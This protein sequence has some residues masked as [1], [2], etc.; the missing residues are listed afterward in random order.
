MPEA[1]FCRKIKVVNTN[2]LWPEYTLTEN[3]Y[4]LVIPV[5]IG[6]MNPLR[7]MMIICLRFRI[8]H[9]RFQTFRSVCGHRQ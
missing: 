3:V 9:H 8:F 1:V 6:E 4:Q 2:I 5:D 7:H